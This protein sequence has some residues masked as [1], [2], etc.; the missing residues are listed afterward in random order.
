MRDISSYSVTTNTVALTALGS[1][2][3]VLI[4]P[5]SAGTES[6]WKS[7][8][9]LLGKVLF[10]GVPMPWTKKRLQREKFGLSSFSRWSPT[11]P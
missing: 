4:S 2:K 6:N 9:A 3:I 7:T 5:D 10:S 1:V 8:L 11:A